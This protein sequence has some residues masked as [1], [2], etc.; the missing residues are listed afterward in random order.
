MSDI[1]DK[2]VEFKTRGQAFCIAAVVATSGSTPRSAGAKGL[3]F[4]DGTIV[5]TVGGG[6][7]EV[8]AI[9]IAKS[10][11]ESGEP[12]LK[13]LSLSALENEMFCGG[14][15]TLYFDPVLPAQRLTIFGGGH[16]GRAIA[17]AAHLLDWQIIVVDQR[18]A[19]LNQALFP[20]NSRLVCIDYAA[21][22]QTHSFSKSDWVV[23]ATPQHE[24][25]ESVLEQVL[26]H[27]ARYVGM[28]ASKSKV[29]V[30]MGNLR[31]KGIEQK[32]LD[33]VY[34]PV[35]LNIGT[36]TPAEIAIAIVA[37]MLAIKNDIR[38]VRSCSR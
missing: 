19:I 18:E 35:G 4:P 33:R 31:N 25:D 34:S 38:E 5:G 15:M 21:Y 36:E 32:L 11:L 16:V 7:I 3:I 6:P 26:A 20:E 37:E 29:K 13:E 8:E 30:I 17:Q 2:I 12:L 1:F 10:V 23:I 22:L 27:A 24:Y 14:S 9:K 28:L